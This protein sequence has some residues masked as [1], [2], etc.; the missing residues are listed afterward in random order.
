M[1]K[2]AL[3]ATILALALSV[4]AQNITFGTLPPV[5]SPTAL[6][7]GYGNLDWAGFSYVAPGW[8]GAGAGFQQ[9]PSGLN[10]AFMGGHVCEQTAALC[11]GSIS[12][13]AAAN[14]L[15]SFHPKSAIVAAG[16]HAEG[17]T[18][19]VYNHGQFV[20][21]QSYNLTTRLQEID[22]PDSWGAITQ[23]VME[24]TQGTVVLYALNITDPNNLVAASDNGGP[25]GPP[26]QNV[27]PAVSIPILDPPPPGQL[28]QDGSLSPPIQYPGPV[29]NVGPKCIPQPN[30]RGLLC[31]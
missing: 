21:S 24:T 22:F 8:S 25:S 5:F 1:K 3:L 13:H 15:S 28:N 7:N 29:A 11:S 2:A 4:S 17:I 10:V 9:G 18:V 23:L 27:G 31:E 30:A 19:T 20:G 26:V 14:A 6:P 16:Y 12:R